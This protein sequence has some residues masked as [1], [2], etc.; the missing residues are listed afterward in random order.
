QTSLAIANPNVTPVSTN[1]K[2]KVTATI[3][4]FQEYG[5][6]L[7]SQGDDNA[8]FMRRHTMSGINAFVLGLGLHL[9]GLVLT[10]ILLLSAQRLHAFIEA[11]EDDLLLSSSRGDMLL[12]RPQQA[13]IFLDKTKGISFW[14]GVGLAL[15]GVIITTIVLWF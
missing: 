10:I 14:R 13:I 9:G 3:A 6:Q 4:L 15:L 8:Q 12:H 1:V 2:G 11:D 5:W 7:I